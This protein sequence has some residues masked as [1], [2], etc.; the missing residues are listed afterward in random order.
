MSQNAIAYLRCSDSKQ[1]RSVDDQQAAI[2]ARAQQ[3]GV[4]I[5]HWFRDDGISGTTVEK[6]PGMLALRKWVEDTDCAGWVLYAWAQ[7]RLGRDTADTVTTLVQ[8]LRASTWRSGANAG[9]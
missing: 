7:S 8:Q 9:S 3:D 4:R 2:V 1:D 5:V 6:R